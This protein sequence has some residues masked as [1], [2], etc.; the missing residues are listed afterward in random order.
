MKTID[1]L[2]DIIIKDALSRGHALMV[3]E[4]AEEAGELL[5]CLEKRIPASSDPVWQD[6]F[7][8]ERRHLATALIRKKEVNIY[9]VR[10]FKNLDDADSNIRVQLYSRS[11][12]RR[13]PNTSRAKK[14]K[15]K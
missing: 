6:L 7:P 9:S 13:G 11:P 12:R 14:K 8:N 1:E 4:N 5:A 10:Y 15:R 3:C 2:A